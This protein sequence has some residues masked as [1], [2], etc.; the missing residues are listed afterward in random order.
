MYR[1]EHHPT[2]VLGAVVLAACWL[3]LLVWT[4]RPNQVA[5]GVHAAAEQAE[6]A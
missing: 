4:V 2:D 5:V 6:A 3:S 1:G